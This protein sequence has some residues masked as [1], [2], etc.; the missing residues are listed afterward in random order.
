M[1]KI[2]IDIENMMSI[3]KTV[4]WVWNMYITDIIYIIY[5][6][7]INVAHYRCISILLDNIKS[8]WEIFN[9]LYNEQPTGNV[10]PS[11]LYI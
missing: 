6:L 7:K 9:V 3:N 4:K 5:K 10:S 2:R 8:N 11:C 1:N